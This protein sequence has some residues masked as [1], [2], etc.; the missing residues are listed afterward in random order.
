MTQKQFEKF[1]K[2]LGISV[3]LLMLGVIMNKLFFPKMSLAIYNFIISIIPFI[4]ILINNKKLHIYKKT[5]YF[6]LLLI[7]FVR[8]IT[9]IMS[10]S[11]L[12]NYKIL[13]QLCYDG[14]LIVILL[15]FFTIKNNVSYNNYK[16]KYFTKTI[17][18]MGI[19]YGIYN[20]FANIANLVYFSNIK[21]RYL[22]NY[23]SFFTNKNLFGIFLFLALVSLKLDS[24][25]NK[26]KKILIKYFLLFNLVL[27][28]SRNAILAYLIFESILALLKKRYKKMAML[29]FII[30]IVIFANIYGLKD[31][32]INY[33]I[34]TDSVTSGREYIWK[35][36]IKY[37]SQK[38]ILGYGEIYISNLVNR[39][40]G[41]TSMHSWLFKILLNG[42]F[43]NLICYLTLL[44]NILYITIKNMKN[45]LPYSNIIFSFI[46]S[47]LAY[48]I[49]EEVNLFEFGLIN[50]IITV[51]FV[52][53]PVLY[54]RGGLNNE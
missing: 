53:L 42:G 28:L 15:S 11:K 5:M 54:Y 36:C 41:V 19:V 31:F 6:V 30:L 49:F 13:E 47:I 51:Y 22:I 10:F 50:I 37:F 9:S 46:I 25:G 2:L 38:P 44:I 27:T 43:I 32:L 1:D 18:F 34:R 20:I 3:F 21:Y 35:I 4:Y 14:S 16:F 52:F 17:V 45:N 12:S 33:I 23:S 8:L 7:I 40:S 24:E 26:R 29:L 48:G 39:E